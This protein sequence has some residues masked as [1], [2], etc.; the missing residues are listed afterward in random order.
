MAEGDD[1]TM[2]SL[3]TMSETDS[4]PQTARQDSESEAFN[5][6]NMGNHMADR[7]D[8]DDSMS[9]NSQAFE[10]NNRM[11][12]PDPRNLP[13]LSPPAD[14]SILYAHSDNGD[15]RSDGLLSA[16]DARAMEQHLD[17]VESSFLPTVSPI[18]K[19]G[20]AGA[21]DTYLFDANRNGERSPALETQTPKKNINSSE[22]EGSGSPPTPDG[23]YKTPGPAPRYAVQVENDD[24][25]QS[26][27]TTSALETLSSPTA[28]AAAR[29][30]SRAMSVASMGENFETASQSIS[31]SKAQSDEEDMEA[32]PTRSSQN[33]RAFSESTN[34]SSSP[35][36]E[37]ST[38]SI[39][40]SLAVDAGATLGAA[41]SASNNSR[42]KFLRSRHSSQRSSVSSFIT[43]PEHNDD[44]SDLTPGADYALQSGGAVPSAGLSRSG[45][46][47]LS[48]T[49]SLGSM[50]SGIDETGD[51]FGRVEGPLATL[52]EE[53]MNRGRTEHQTNSAPETPR[54]ASRPMDPPTDTIIARHVRNVQVPESM[55]KDF[56]TKHGVHTP[57]KSASFAASAV[58][59]RNG[60]NLTLKEQSSTIER[61]SKE[62]FDLKLKVMFLSDRLDK[63]SEEGVKEMI[64][65]NVELKTGL[66]VM[67]RDN[68]ALRKKVKDLEK[69][70]KDDEDRPSTAR[71]GT[72]TEGSQRW[73]QEG[74]FEREEELLYL[75]EKVEEYLTEIERLRNESLVREN[76]KR[77]LADLVRT[78][79][80]RRGQNIETREEMDVWKDLLEQ[81]TARREQSD[82]EIKVLR[83]EIFR[84]K[85]EAT[86]GGHGLNHTTN[87]YNIAKKRVGSPSRSNSNM[88]DRGLDERNGTYSSAGTLVEEIRRDNEQLRHENAELRR[89][90]GAQ[91]SMLT[92]RNREKERLYQEIEDLKLGQR[93]G[94]TSVAGESIFERSASRA[95]ERS[96]SRTSAGTRQANMSEAERE[97]F[98]NKQAEL[99]DRIN[100]LK[101]H[102]QD[103]TRELESCIE[104]FETAVEQKK[105]AVGLA[106]ELQ[107]AL[108]VAENDLLTMQA[109]RDEALRGQEE[110]EL[111]F[112]SLHKE[113]QEELDGFAAEQEE[114]NAEIERLQAE[115]AEEKE[116]FNALQNEMREMSDIVVRL[117]DDH[118]RKSKKIQEL[119][120]ELDDANREL[121]EI[122]KN[123]VESNEKVNRLNVQQESSQNEIAFLREEQDGDKIKI[124]DLE[125]AIR[126]LEQSLQEEQERAR[127]LDERLDEER[128]Q[129]E[130]VA[131]QEKQEIQQFVN[132]LNREATTAK[133]EVRRLRKSLTSREVEAAEWKQRLMELENNLREALGDV[134]GTRSSLLNAIA[135]LQREHEKNVRDLDTAKAALAEKERMIKQRDDLLESH[136]LESRK[137][138]DMLDKERQTHRLTKNQYETSQ[139]TSSHTTRTLSQQESRVLELEASRQ[140]DRRKIAQL[141]NNFKEQL[142]ERNNLLLNMWS[143]L[144]SLCGTD[145]SHNNSLINGRALPSLEAVSTMFPG[146]SK[147]LLAAVKTIETLVG[148]FR[149]RVKDLDRR[150]WKEYST[151]ENRFEM[152][153]KKLDRL[154]T[155]A[156]SAV[157]LNSMDSRA[158]VVKLK[159]LNRSLKTEISNLKAANGVYEPTSPFPSVPTGPRRRID[160]SLS[161]SSTMTRHSSASAPASNG[162]P[163]VTT[164]S[165]NAMT[166]T[167]GD[168]EYKP[169]LRWQVRLQELEYKLKAEREARKL[170]RSSAAQRLREKDRENKELVEQMER[171][172]VRN[173]RFGNGSGG[174]GGG[175]EKSG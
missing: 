143:R 23:A 56:R 84:L 159:D 134:N 33:L 142:T 62:N 126:N 61:L 6:H 129:R 69:Q 162:T 46:M 43:N 121:E 149:G 70:L 154:E 95:H 173:G 29:T 66:A 106:Q 16:M 76:E 36:H 128:H 53:D 12:S 14:S 87:I 109:D 19:H 40:Q 9:M 112:E 28:A 161:R 172:R 166:R 81:E 174:G 130:V 74:A 35:N 124:G 145:W 13:T 26:G 97:E 171:G 138:A 38:R 118:E 168:E 77:N 7:S 54:A 139:K 158:E 135:K 150:L 48:R 152:Q 80:E 2:S 119:E 25:E 5:F 144:A 93:R 78:M 59:H 41:L 67:Q 55:A 68:K 105:D 122:E 103:L 132:D 115:V 75:R 60:K 111:M 136:A 21:D 165:S 39:N 8:N 17:N 169:D 96:S 82:D 133:D 44:R 64:S 83:E 3:S 18:G 1:F 170:D 108:D 131:N 102:N 24:S 30:I 20:K 27:N 156:R 47:T 140:Q 71:S 141:E 72:S 51:S 22:S 85:S 88:S 167:E 63:L 45:S 164:S 37:S 42:P 94:G 107:E 10:E 116:N 148:D 65:E 58:A 11:Q 153:T 57:S 52:A 89:E 146:F 157:P 163:S 79:G 92:S 100:S 160:N 125:A 120:R 15:N 147:N 31:Q 127:E 101:I 34:D 114:A 117:E 110:A 123:Y 155:M 91:T 104:D 98:E 175:G 4:R 73:Y 90:V 99:R 86:A 113:A 151:L 32:T 137:L 50:A 49:I